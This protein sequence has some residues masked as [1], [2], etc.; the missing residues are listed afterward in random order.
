MLKLNPNSFHAYFHLGGIYKE[1]KI[2]EKSTDCYKKVLELNPNHPEAFVRLME[3][4]DETCHWQ[5]FEANHQRLFTINKAQI[6][7]GVP[8]PIAQLYSIIY[9]WPPQ[10]LLLMSRHNTN[11]IAKQ[12]QSLVKKLNFKF[13]QCPKTKLKIGYLS[14]DFRNHPVA[15]LTNNLYSTHD[16]NHFEIF[17]FSHGIDDGSVYRKHIESTCDHF[18][19]LY[20]K[21]DTEIAKTIYASGIDILMDLNG[22]TDGDKMRVL[23]LK[24]SPIQAQYIGYLGTTGASFIDYTFVDDIVITNETAS[25]YSEKL[26][27]LPNC[28]QINDDQQKISDKPLKRSDY[29]LPEDAFVFC[30]FNSSYKIE[31]RVFETWMKILADAPNAVLWLVRNSPLLETNLRQEAIKKGIQPERLIFT[32]YEEKS[33]YLARYRLANLFLDTFVYNANTTGSDALWAGLPLLTCPGVHY[34][35]RGA[36]T[37]LKTLDLNELITSDPMKYYETAVY[38]YQNPQQLEKIR[39]KLKVQCKSSPLFD[40]KR[41]VRNLEQA[42]FKMWDIYACGLPPQEIRIKERD[43]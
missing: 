28:Y 14:S 27:Y 29:Q 23:A 34:A 19:D 2:V 4:Y 33:I 5:D 17:A 21:T 24:P 9:N 42:Y 22:H 32:S 38:F 15:Y 31:P 10:E 36:A 13:D 18:I 3:I 7:A 30:C 39:E 16:R 25:A 1:L 35:S 40:T 11:L 6:A 41:F 12:Q 8:S 20:K 37:M 43:A 26:V